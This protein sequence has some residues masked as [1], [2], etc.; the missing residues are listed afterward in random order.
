V[1][2]AC[3]S[4][5]NGSGVEFGFEGP[6]V[7]NGETSG[8]FFI[9]CLVRAGH[10][11]LN[12]EGH[13][14]AEVPG[15]V[16]EAACYRALGPD[17]AP[18]IALRHLAAGTRYRTLVEG[19]DS[20]LLVLL[21][22]AIRRPWPLVARDFPIRRVA[23]LRGK[24]I[25]VLKDGDSTLLTDETLRAAGVPGSSVRYKVMALPDMASAPAEHSVDAAWMTEP[26]ITEAAMATGAEELANTASGS[27]ADFPAGGTRRCGRTPR[28]SRR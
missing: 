5:P 11:A 10:P 28:L 25:A 20:D 2:T 15:T 21:T 16:G 27:T 22:V 26:F 12:F 17:P 24:T 18:E 7:G 19:N 6:F 8:G 3:G 4:Q 1:P 13:P 23:Q 9:D 14:A